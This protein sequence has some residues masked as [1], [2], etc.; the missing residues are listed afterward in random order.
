MKIIRSGPV[1]AIVL[2]WMA[3]VFTAMIGNVSGDDVILGE[4]D[5]GF[6]LP[7]S[8]DLRDVDGVNY[9]TSVKSQQ[10]GTCWTHGAMAAME[11]N[12][13]M[14]G[15]WV[16]AGESGEPNLAEYHLDWWNGFNEH[17]NDDID[18]PNGSGLEVHKGGDYRVTSA[19]LSRG[20]G[21][22]RDIDG[23]SY[24]TPP[25]RYNSSY[26]YYYARDIEW[27]VAEPDLSNIDTI[28]TKIM[29]DGVI[30]TCMC[31]HSSFMQSPEL[32]H[33]QPPDNL[34]EPNHA[35]AIV[36]WNDS[37]A[38]QA[39]LPG[40][41]LCKNSW[42]TGWGYSG[43]FW[44]SYYDK[45]TCQ[46]PEM[47]AVSFQDVQYLAYN[48]TY[49]HDYHGWRDTLENYTE[50]FN[51]FVATD[52]EQLQAV[53]FYTAADN[54][55]FTVKIYDRFE[56]GELL[57]EL[58]TKSATIEYEGFHT[59][60]LDTPV[61]LV[62]GDDFYIY[63]FLSV[64]GHPYDRT[65][66]VPVLLG[67]PS[68]GT[69]VESASNPGES[70]YL[71][72]STWHDLYDL[73]D[74]ANFCIKG[75]VGHLSVMHPSEGD[76]VKG[77]I[78]ITGTAS[79]LITE[80][81]VKIDGGPWQSANC[82]LNWSYGWN[83]T[84]YADGLNTIYARAYNGSYYIERSVN[85]IIDN[86]DPTVA[87]TS[88]LN[89][90]YISEKNVT[91]NWT[92]SDDTSS[93][94]YYKAQIDGGTWTNV[95]FATNQTYVSLS[96]GAH[97]VKVNVTDSVG[98]KN[99]SRVLFTID[100]IPPTVT[101]TAPPAFYL[102]NV[103]NVTVEWIGDDT[104]SGVN[105][106]EVRIDEG[107]WI[108]VGTS[109]SY[110]FIGLTTGLHTVDVKAFDGAWNQGMDSG[111]FTVDI[112][113]PEIEDITTDTPTTGD[114]FILRANLTD[115][116]VVSSVYVE[117]WYDLDAHNNVS[118]SKSGDDW[119]YT[120]TPPKDAE[121]LYYIF[122][123]NDTSDNWNT[124]SLRDLAVIDDDKPVFGT[125]GT[126]TTAA[127]GDSLIFAIEVTDNIE[128]YGAWVEYWYG[129]GAHG[130]VSMAKGIENVWEHTIMLIDTLEDLH[131]IFHTN[132]T[133]DNWNVTT[134]KTVIIEDN[135]R[136][137]FWIDGTTTSA[138]TGDQFTFSIEVADNIDIHNVCVGYWFGSETCV[139]ESMDHERDCVWNHTITVPHSL[140]VLHYLFCAN[141][142]SSNWNLTSAKELSVSDNDEPTASA[143]DNVY[144]NV[145]T[146]VFFDGLGSS[147]NIGVVNYTWHIL[148]DGTDIWLYGNYVNFVFDIDDNYT[149]ELTVKDA[150]G[151]SGTDIIWVNVTPLPDNYGDGIPDFYDDEYD[152]VC[153]SDKME[154]VMGTNSFV[155]D[156]DG[157]GY[158]DNEDYDPLNPNKWQMPAEKPREVELP[159]LFLLILIILIIVM[160]I[161]VFLLS[162]KHKSEEMPFLPPV[163]GKELPPPPPDIAE[164][165]LPPPPDDDWPPPPE[166][167]V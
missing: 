74:T 106:Y 127:T 91:V 43:Y 92:G 148:Y 57:D 73:N 75:L 146:N 159:L 137:T 68:D 105:H 95:G 32:T 107:T 26:H 48:H 67:G 31:Y 18:P 50:A 88:P 76:Y 24:D 40:A 9:V 51:V 135:D 30:G 132:D 123:A 33:Y 102:F 6:G 110:T 81:E 134:V 11:G 149:V 35:V 112:T 13:L 96:E 19:Y 58:S 155:Q 5:G 63:I 14:T 29:T 154:G 144:C 115:F 104:N 116:T 117:Y 87:I 153:L 89:G 37:M 78:T 84:F 80:I 152:N 53:S 64:G 77:N 129:T 85:V 99:M 27:Y 118:M 15:N 122:R 21:A 108:D 65:S 158:N 156:T 143:G 83:T 56:G 49:Y 139:N 111:T 47:G 66:Y 133:S 113:P 59:I 120:I 38:T 141:D 126:A 160:L 82:T 3:V 128:V 125:D 70:Y 114:E 109:S 151:L 16:A 79:S 157:D 52:D 62:G 101:I 86:T 41:W 39:P 131:Y 22:V 121:A 90:T 34:S 54:V 147:D 8:Y 4:Q 28:K 36:G 20:E 142:T 167:E 72:G 98:H 162:K 150:A 17:N 45:H 124:T 42:G 161:V 136:P 69:L 165:E 10:G 12:L 163:A 55:D 61:N 23:Q 140:D 71:N 7:G 166:D 1:F 44:I 100:T 138:T 46:H 60:D 97:I 103:S 145:S 94:A 2:V 130:E 164:K 93:V 25:E 119:A